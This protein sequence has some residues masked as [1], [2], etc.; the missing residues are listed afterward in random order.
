MASTH[1]HR[2]AAHRVR[3]PLRVGITGGIGSG[4]TTVAGEFLRL[5]FPVIFADEI[6]KSIADSS[7]AVRR[8]L[9]RILGRDAYRANGRLN[10]SVVASRIFSDPRLR[11]RMEAVIHP[12]V[13]REVDRLFRELGRRGECLA[14]VEAALIFEAK[15]ERMLHAVVVVDAPAAKRLARV[16]RRDGV[17]HEAVRRRMANQLPA[18]EKRSRADVV[19]RNN[20]TRAQLRAQVRFLAGLLHSTAHEH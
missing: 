17:E 12:R 11:R 15:M 1:D 9:I 8:Q 2:T 13:E 18:R 20:G 16:R 3:L 10:R 19:I 4:K 5:G 7:A 6:A 14:F